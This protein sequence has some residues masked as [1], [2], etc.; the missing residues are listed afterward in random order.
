MTILLR[1]TLSVLAGPIVFFILL[2]AITRIGSHETKGEKK[3]VERLNYEIAAWRL[4]LCRLEA[5][6]KPANGNDIFRFNQG[7]LDQ[8]VTHESNSWRLEFS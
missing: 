4:G 3:R 8:I 5:I 1:D 2:G 6:Q 7:L